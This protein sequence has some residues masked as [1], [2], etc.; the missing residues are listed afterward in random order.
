MSEGRGAEG[1]GSPGQDKGQPLDGEETHISYRRMAVYNGKR[2]N[3]GEVFNF[4]WSCELNEP[5]QD[6]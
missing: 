6:F 5:R 3:Y 1:E 2:G 4:N